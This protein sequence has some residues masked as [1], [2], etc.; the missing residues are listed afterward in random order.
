M[1]LYEKILEIA[2]RRGI[3]FPSFDIYGGLAGFYD[4][5]PYGSLLK[6]NILEVWKKFYIAR[7]GFLL[8]DTPNIMPYQV[9][10]A[11]GHVDRFTDV[12]VECEQCGN[13]FRADKVL[14]DLGI[15]YSSKEEIFKI[16]EEREVKCPLC[17]GRLS[18]P[19]EVNLMFGTEVGFGEKVKA[20]LRPE[21]AQ[22]IFIDFP[23]LYNFARKKL[24]MGVAQIGKGFRN[25]ISPRQGIIRLREF[26]MAEVEVF[27]DPNQDDHPRFDEIKEEEILAVKRDG[28]SIKAK[29]GELLEKGII[30]G[31]MLAY[32]I[33]LTKKILCSLGIDPEKLRFR[34]H[35][36]EELAHYAKDCWDAEVYLERFGWTE[37]VGIANRTSYDLEAHSKATGKDL[38]A[39]R[40]LPEPK[41]VTEKKYVL[42]MRIAGPMLREKA[43][44]A[45]EIVERGKFQIEGDKAIIEVEGE[46]L[47]LPK[48]AIVEEVEEKYVM[49]EPFTPWVVEPSYGIDR[50]LYAVLEHSYSEDERGYSFFKLKPYL[51]PIKVGVF[52]IVNKEPFT[53]IAIDIYQKLVD[54][55][56]V[57]FYDANDSIGRRYARMDEI[58]TPYCITVDGQTPEDWTV[59]IRDRD[60]RKQ[61]RLKIPKA[62]SFIEEKT[63]FK[64]E[65][66]L[67]RTSK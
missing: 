5:G 12:L 40:N 66:V 47:E 39:L 38:K 9:L 45:A 44:K 34:Q 7:E 24:P 41:K 59:T 18:R 67:G 21:T 60:T 54:K 14:E 2:K 43:K 52:P 15:P 6:D 8:V 30:R 27:F 20:F 61:I 51:A 17:G 19:R 33:G 53:S 16:F 25:E 3:F 32:Y 35:R 65:E 49:V 64:L 1:D 50:I 55:G 11:S 28:E 58:G 22:G 4:Y 62:I 63:K 48:E 36:E 57:A 26:N 56:I 29:I 10:K 13:K 46:K 37:V 31:K 42:D 23:L